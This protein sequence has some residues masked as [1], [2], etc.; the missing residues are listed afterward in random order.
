MIIYTRLN[1]L[2]TKN[3]RISGHD[4]KKIEIY[5][6]ALSSTEW[7][8]NL[9]CCSLLYSY[10]EP[11]S[12]WNK[13]GQQFV[14]HSELKLNRLASGLHYCAPSVWLLCS[15]LQNFYDSYFQSESA[16]YGFTE[17]ASIWIIFN[18]IN[19]L[20][21]KSINSPKYAGFFVKMSIFHYTWAARE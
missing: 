10:R 20:Q 21:S 8:N 17:A 19:V 9:W 5:C 6:H 13:N 15:L 4:T 3:L 11:L 18:P 1:I 14:S 7:G 16:R 2:N 12:P